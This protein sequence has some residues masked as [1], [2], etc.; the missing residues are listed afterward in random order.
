MFK[1]AGTFVSA[2]ALALLATSGPASAHLGHLG[3][4][5]GHSHWTGAAAL[6]GAVIAAGILA[7]KG[8]KKT[9]KAKEET[10]RTPP[11]V[12]PAAEGKPA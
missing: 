9:A 2:S 11:G 3:E 8:R 12:E 4:L 5:A 6:A 10:N 7:V 1:A